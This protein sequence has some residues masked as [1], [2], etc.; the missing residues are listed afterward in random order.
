MKK[1][2]WAILSFVFIYVVGDAILTEVNKSAKTTRLECQKRAITFERIYIEKDIKFAQKL[3][4]NGSVKFTS[5]VQKAHYSKSKL[6]E[7]VKLEDM[8]TV[9]KNALKQYVKEKTGEE[10]TLNISYYIYENDIKDPGK[11][12]EKSKLYAGYVVFRFYNQKKEPIYQIQLDF[13]DKKGVDLPQRIKCAI[14]SFMTLNHK[15]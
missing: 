11:K 6:F 5:S 3:L 14:K 1:Y 12:T 8:D 10:K 4:N 9:L 13:I 7:Y 2:I 15:I